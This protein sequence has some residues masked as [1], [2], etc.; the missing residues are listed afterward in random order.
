M[1]DSK[2]KNNIMSHKD[3][4]NSSW[5]NCRNIF[6]ETC[7]HITGW[8][9]GQGISFWESEIGVFSVCSAMLDM[10]NIIKD[11]DQMEFLQKCRIVLDFSF[12]CL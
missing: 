1:G 4:Q 3:A 7:P 2:C 6:V 11:H 5:E 10:S 9:S 8:W 12:E